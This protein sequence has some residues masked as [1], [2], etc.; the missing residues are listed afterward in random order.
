ML[1]KDEKPEETETGI[2]YHNDGEFYVKAKNYWSTVDA[3][4]DGMLG[5]FSEISVKELQSSRS[6]LEEIYK[7]RPCPEKKQALDCGA[8]IGRVSKGLLI[9]FFEKVCPLIYSK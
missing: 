8:G 2:D 5:G 9:P 3:N 4:V 7:S 1:D 6:F